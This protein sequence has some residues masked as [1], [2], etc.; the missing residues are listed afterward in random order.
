MYRA[1]IYVTIITLSLKGEKWKNN[2]QDI[3]V[4]T[5]QYINILVMHKTFDEWNMNEKMQL[6]VL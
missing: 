4:Y 6:N 5:I 2:W 1:G 3:C